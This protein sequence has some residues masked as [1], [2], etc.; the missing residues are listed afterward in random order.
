MFHS[1]AKGTQVTGITRQHVPYQPTRL[2]HG[3]NKQHFTMYL[4]FYVG[5]MLSV[6][7]ITGLF[8]S[9]R[10]IVHVKADE[11][12]YKYKKCTENVSEMQK[13]LK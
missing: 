6:V 1:R 10:I 8:K 3:F 9:Q 4:S 11:G 13:N 5:I 12:I 2:T 7:N